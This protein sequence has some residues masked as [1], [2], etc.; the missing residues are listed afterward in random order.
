MS[1]SS[2][3]AYDVLIVGARVAGASL[4]LLLGQRGHRVLMVDRDRFPSDT[5]STHYMSH[6]HVDLLKHL[7]ILA[8]VEAAG[9]RRITRARSYIEDCLFEAPIGPGDS[10]ALAPRR[11][12]LDSLLIEHA[13]RHGSVEFRERTRVVGLIEEDGRV[14]G[15]RIT[16]PGGVTEEVRA[17]VVVGADGKYSDVARWGRAETYESTPA[18]RPAYYGYYEG[19]EP[20]PDTA[21]ELFFVGDHIG[22]L[23]PMQPGMDCIAFEL[24]PSEFAEMRKSPQ[25]SFE[26]MFS[27]LPTMGTRFANARLTGRMIGTRGVENYIRKP[28]G[29]GWVLTGDAGVLMDPSTGVGMGDALGQSFWLA[30]ALDRALNGGGWDTTMAGFQQ[31]RDE[32][33]MPLY[34]LT[35]WFTTLGRTSDTAMTYLRAMLSSPAIAR[36]VPTL[37]PGLV[38]DALPAHLRPILQQNANGFRDAATSVPMA[39]G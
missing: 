3:P 28:Y 35:L 18:I 1:D 11:A 2:T 27:A 8:E 16:T 20:L 17:T 31:Q 7:G 34:R 26:R 38:E 4:G 5:M 19:I 25:A 10:F 29:P 6:W 33:L 36:V 37:F 32:A 14:I 21:V 30:G 15:A 23:F 22:F 9:F 39:A 13:T 12:H 24:Q